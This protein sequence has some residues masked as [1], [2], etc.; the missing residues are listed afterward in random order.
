MLHKSSM[1]ETT[2]PRC[3]ALQMLAEL[4]LEAVMLGITGAGIEKAKQTAGGQLC[5]IAWIHRS[6]LS[7]KQSKRGGQHCDI[8][9]DHR[10]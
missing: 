1:I 6:R 2:N 10:S 3:R 8:A 4:G 9:W 7:T 5:D